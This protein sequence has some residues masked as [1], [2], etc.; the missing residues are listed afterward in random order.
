[1]CYLRAPTFSNAV[2]DVALAG[3]PPAP[4]GMFQRETSTHE[5]RG[6]NHKFWLVEKDKGKRTLGFDLSPLL[7]QVMICHGASK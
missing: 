2:L 7:V 4:I 6:D 1:M 5:R 3:S